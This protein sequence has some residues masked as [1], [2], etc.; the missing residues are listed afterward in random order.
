MSQNSDSHLLTWHC[1]FLRCFWEQAQKDPHERFFHVSLCQSL[2]CCALSCLIAGNLR[3][4]SIHVI[5]PMNQS[6]RD[7]VESFREVLGPGIKERAS[8]V[9][10][11][12]QVTSRKSG[13]KVSLA[14]LRTIKE[15]VKVHGEPSWRKG[16]EK[17]YSLSWSS[18]LQTYQAPS[19][20]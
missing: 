15:T 20:V 3:C 17:T 14:S 6:W 1:I 5:S 11:I 7:H 2:H 10:H 9:W 16:L 12:Q 4:V 19:Y 13:P 8:S 18:L